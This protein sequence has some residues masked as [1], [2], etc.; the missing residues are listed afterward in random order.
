MLDQISPT[1]MMFIGVADFHMHD[2]ESKKLSGHLSYAR[3]PM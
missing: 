2:E 3:G 1:L